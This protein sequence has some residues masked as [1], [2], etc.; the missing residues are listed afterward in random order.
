MGNIGKDD[1]AVRGRAYSHVQPR[2]MRM[3]MLVVRN[4]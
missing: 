3:A 4:V 2:F 1:L